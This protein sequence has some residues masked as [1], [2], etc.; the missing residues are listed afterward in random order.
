[1]QHDYVLK[2]LN[3]DLLGGGKYFSIIFFYFPYVELQKQSFQP[4][5]FN[6]YLS[7]EKKTC[8]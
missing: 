7:N 4:I 2:K 5:V 3:F 8:G 6:W 1:M